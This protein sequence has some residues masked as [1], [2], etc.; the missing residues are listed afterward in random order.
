MKVTP[1]GNQNTGFH[2]WDYSNPN[3]GMSIGSLQRYTSGQHRVDYDAT[4]NGNTLEIVVNGVIKPKG[5]SSPAILPA[6][7][8]VFQTYIPD[9]TFS[10]DKA[11]RTIKGPQGGKLE[12]IL[13]DNCSMS[14]GKQDLYEC[15]L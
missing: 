6:T 4:L 1:K 7:S 15:I 14:K 8:V 11:T 10:Y 3:P 9:S 2:L 13:K 5:T 12:I